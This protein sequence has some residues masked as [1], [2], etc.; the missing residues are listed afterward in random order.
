MYLRK[1]LTSICGEADDIEAEALKFLGERFL[2][3]DAKYSILAVAGGHDGDAKIDE[4]ALIFHAEAAVL[5]DAALGDVQIAENFYAREN[6]RVP[7]FRD[8]L[9]GVLEDA[10]D[11]VLDGDFGVAGFDVDVTG[12]AFKRGKN[13]GFDE[14]DDRA[15]G[16][17]AAR[18][19]VA[20]N[21]LFALFFF[22]GDLESESFG[23]LFEDAL[24]LFG[25]LED[26][27]DLASGGD[28]DGELLAE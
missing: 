21:G 3:E 20:G 22:L 12:A 27:A 5:R 26:V 24:G 14:A 15:D 1:C 23:G 11:A 6:G 10:V 17:V 9:H 4:A 8:G 7:L 28:L 16:G 13:D 2:I 25:A 19:A 18:K